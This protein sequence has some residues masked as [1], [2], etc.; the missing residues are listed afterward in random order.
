MGERYSPSFGIHESIG[1]IQLPLRCSATL[2][3]NATNWLVAFC[4]SLVHYADINILLGMTVKRPDGK[5]QTFQ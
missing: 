4:A 5:V 3:D 2:V 1:L